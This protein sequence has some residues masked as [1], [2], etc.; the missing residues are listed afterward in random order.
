MAAFLETMDKQNKQI[1]ILL[2]APGS[3]KGTQGI[4]LSEKFNLYYLETSGILEK[5]FQHHKED[6]FMEIDGEKYSFGQEKKNWET[7]L[8]VSP[9][10]ATRL[11]MEKI[12]ELHKE[13]K[14]LLMSGSPRTLYEAELVFPLLK[15]LYGK[16]N[17]K[18]ILIE[19]GVEHT[20][21]R[22]SHRRICELMRH[23]ILY[24]D[25]TKELEHCP[26]D[27]SKLI[28]RE[29][30]D[31]PETIKIRIKEYQERTFPLIGFFEKQGQKVE[32]INGEQSVAEVHSDVLKVLE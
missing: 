15:E 29:G 3:G 7:G 19:V 21:F 22:N 24:I 32:K 5:S 18:I 20:I 10:F 1:I 23:P 31:E 8:L 2:G 27:G 30:L 16:E 14:S 13:G 12:K 4:L 9:P 11:I 28:R 17:I 26:L 6:E 25:E